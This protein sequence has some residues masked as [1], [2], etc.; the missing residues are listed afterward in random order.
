[1]LASLPFNVAAK[2]YERDSMILT[3]TQRADALHLPQ[4]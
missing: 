1:M 4:S 3:R 2:L